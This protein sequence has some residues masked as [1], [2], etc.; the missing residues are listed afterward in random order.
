MIH[1]SGSELKGLIISI[2]KLIKREIPLQFEK[3]SAEKK[4][5]KTYLSEATF[6][7]GP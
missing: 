5:E 1:E 2:K 4:E 7:D 6:S 3:F